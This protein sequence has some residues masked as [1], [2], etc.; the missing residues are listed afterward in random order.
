MGFDLGSTI[1]QEASY[2]VAEYRG[3]SEG[4]GLKVGPSVTS[5]SCIVV[6]VLVQLCV[7]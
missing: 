5:L 2:V 1:S 6:L 4:R 7:G 3:V